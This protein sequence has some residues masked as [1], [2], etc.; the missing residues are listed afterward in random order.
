[1]KHLSIEQVLTLH[2]LIVEQSGGSHGLRDRGALE[3]ARAQ[4]QMSFG[5]TELYATPA[6]KAAAP[7]F[8]LINNHPF[9]DGNKRIGL[10]AAVAFL[11]A[12]GLD[13][14]GSTDELESVVLAVAGSEM[15][16][17]AWTQWVRDH[18]QPCPA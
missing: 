12:N 15:S 14:S 1:M 4:P 18:I 5:E 7:G 11:R 6:E 2:R 16:R 10:A 13:L 9:V 8:S 3:S 17:E